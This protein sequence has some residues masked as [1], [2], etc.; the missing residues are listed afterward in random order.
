MR[1]LV[2]SL[3]LGV[4]V[5]GCGGD[6][7]SCRRYGVGCDA[8]AERA[9]DRD[10]TCRM[11]SSPDGTGDCDGYYALSRAC[12]DCLVSAKCEVDPAPCSGCGQKALVA[13]KSLCSR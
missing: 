9:C 3:V 4:V 12:L 10:F 7:T 1:A 11:G 6:P 8:V 13:C 5:A 2:R